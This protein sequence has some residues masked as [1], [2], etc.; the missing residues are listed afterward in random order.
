MIKIKTLFKK[1]PKDLGRVI[2]EINPLNSWVMSVVFL[3]GNL[4]KKILE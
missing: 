1:D 2:N 3:Q 4:T